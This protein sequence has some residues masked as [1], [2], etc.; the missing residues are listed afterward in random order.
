LLAPVSLNDGVKENEELVFRDKLALE[1]LNL[2]VL[3]L[4]ICLAKYEYQ[5]FWH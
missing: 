1:A 5:L 4:A 2:D 3:V